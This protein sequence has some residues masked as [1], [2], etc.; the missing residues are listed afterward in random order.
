MRTYFVYLLANRSRTLYVGITNDLERRLREHRRKQNPGFTSKYNIDQLVYYEATNDIHVAI[1]REKQ[2]KGWLRAK[3]VALIE[4]VNPERRDLGSGSFGDG[5]LFAQ[6]DFSVTP[7]VSPA[8]ALRTVLNSDLDH[9]F[10]QQLDPDANWMAAF[11]AKSAVDR[12][13]F[14]AHWRRNLVDP[15]VLIRTVVL[16]DQVAGYVLSY[17]EAGRTE[18]SYW[19][20]REFWGRGIATSAL[21]AF[22]ALQTKRPLH[23]RA[24]KD[25]AASLRVLQRCGFQICGEDSGFANARQ[26]V[27]EEWLLVLAAVQD[28]QHENN[29]CVDE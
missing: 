2:I 20:G 7:D 24:A 22:L 17:E 16:A 25:N 18:V 28:P 27:I 13:A 3:K 14:D 29:R 23:A 15:T 9:F 10:R 5:Q 1:A 8:T 21:A 12:A 11:T 26:A 19:V 4:A 6:K